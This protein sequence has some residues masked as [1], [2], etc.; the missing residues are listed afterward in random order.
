MK[1]KWKELEEKSITSKKADE[2]QDNSGD[3]FGGRKV[4]NQQ[5]RSD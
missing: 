4:K 3:Q 2:P 1:A 5:K